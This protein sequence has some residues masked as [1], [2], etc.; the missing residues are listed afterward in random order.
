MFTGTRDSGTGQTG[1]FQLS[2]FEEQNLAEITHPDRPGERLIVCRNP[3]M[4]EER[5]HRR[6]S[7]LRATERELDQV[8]AATQ[9]E[10]RPFRGSEKIGL[11][12]GLLVNK[13]KVAK[14][15]VLEITEDSFT[16]HRNE[17][18]IT[19]EAMLDGFYVVRT[20]VSVEALAAEEAVLAYK[21]LDGVERA[22]RAFNSD[23][24]LRPIRH[25]KGDRVRA[26]LL[27]RMLAYYV[28]WHIADRAAPILFKDHDRL[29]AAASR[30]SPVAPAVR[31]PSALAKV[32]RQRTDSGDPVHSL[33][34]LLAD[35]ATVAINMIQPAR[36]GSPPFRMI[37]TPTKLQQ[38]AF[39][40][41]G[42][43]PRLG[44]T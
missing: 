24:D 25:W 43:D 44:V 19:T 35:L 22:F 6:E 34:T 23:L 8:I 28:Q 37:T 33:P 21:R 4:T 31:S 11:R 42:V 14:H 18:S 17:V 10:R 26:H 30:S 29:G 32:R 27:L 12:V 13:R 3:N 20:N 9:R 41:L 40:L 36:P 1:A 38:N 16:Y 7:L 39:E 15:F 2:L 5:R